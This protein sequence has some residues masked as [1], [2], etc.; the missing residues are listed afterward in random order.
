MNIKTQLIVT[1]ILL[2]VV[3]AVIPIPITALILIYVIVQ[4]PP[5]FKDVVQKVYKT[6]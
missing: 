6:K 4:K 2:G 3:D 1:L 5:W